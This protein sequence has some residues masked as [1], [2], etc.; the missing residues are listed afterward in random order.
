MALREVEIHVGFRGGVETKSDPKTVPPTKLLVL[1]NGVFT[2]ATSIKKRNGYES[3]SRSID[4]S[5]EVVSGAIRTAARDGELLAFT[6][7]R[8]YSRQTGADQW[9]DAGPVF[10]VVGSD[11]PLVRT[12]T[13][14]L[15]PDAASFAG[16]TV[17]AWEDSIGGVWWSV[18]DA[19]SGRVFRAATQADAAGQ[20]PRCVACGDNLHVYYSVPSTGRIM[21]VV[22]NPAAPGAAVAPIVLVDDLSAT[23]PAYDACETTRVSPAAAAIAWAE[24][25]TASIRIGYVTSAGVLGSPLSGLPSI[26]TH[27]AS[28]GATTPIGIAHGFVDGA[29]ADRLALTYVDG[30]ATGAIATFT[31]GSLASPITVVDLDVTYASTS[32]LRVAVGVSVAAPLTVWV[33]FEEAAVA[34]SNRRVAIISVNPATS[35]ATV[36]PVIRSVGLASRAFVVDADAFAVLVHDTTFFNT[37]VTLRLSDA[38]CIGRHAAA[39]AAGAP[40]RQHLSSAHVAGDIVTVALPVRER[41]VTEINDKFR[42]TGI[43][44]F[45]FDFDSED[46]HQAAQLGR[47]LYMAGACAQHYD[48]RVWTEQGFHFGPELVVTAPAGGGSMTASTTYLYRYWYE[49]TDAQGE[50]HRGPTSTGTIVTMAGGQTQVTHTLPTLRVT[51]KTQVRI[52]VARSLAADTGKTAQLFRVTSLDP[53]TVGVA[54]GYV[55]SSTAVDTVTFLDRMSD[56]TLE[57]QEELYTDG[58]ILSND[59][60]SL[61]SVIARG[62]SR[63][64]FTDPSDGN[65]VRFSQPIDDGYGV[66]IPPDLTI[67]C[68]P[69]GGDITA[70]AFQDGRGVI[71]KASA[72]FLFQGDGP[73]PN[74]DTSTSGFSTPQ[75]VTSDVG[76]T[77]PASIVLTP[78]GHM[79][80]SAK[81]IYLLDR[82]GSVSYIGA[83]VEAYN[84]QAVRRATVMPDRTQVV[85]LTD[86]GLTL[87]FDYLFGEW[88]TFT[89]HEGLDAVVVNN[90]YHYLRTDGRVFR[91]TPGVYSD[92][93]TRIRLRLETAWIRMQD[94][95][96]GFQ[97][98]WYLYLLG[99]WGSP[100]QLGVQYQTDYTPGWSNAY[101]YDATGL[102]SSTGWITGD[103]AAAIGIDPITGTGY[104]DGGYGEGAYGGT[105]P[106]LYQWRL[107]L[108][109]KGQAIQLRFEDFE[110]VGF[111]GASFELTEMLFTGGVIG[112]APRPSIAARSA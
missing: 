30:A 18:V 10:S 14:Q 58:G 111:L 67:R 2:R 36:G 108:S 23:L 98:F 13:Q 83:R 21:V 47:G 9:S 45:A 103:N 61:G 85:F 109:E 41:L 33:A 90:T 1:E 75:L 20:A 82:S 16:V 87:L 72:I 37:Y 31:G 40:L 76:C 69:F 19:V 42:E 77:D 97:V 52:C 102:S 74:G 105:T 88:S 55:L 26:L 60:A 62:Q 54:N 70:L 95:L 91:E 28:R 11:R 96:Q 110:A 106:D 81:G 6:P 64:F 80:K 66:E 29:N 68:D 5:A 15:Q 92:A 99:T 7:R 32:V 4:S 94:Q 63:L 101:W 57:Q 27:A 112:N 3:L 46:S 12:G 24:G 84:A 25:G 71:W 93:G 44:I 59:P 43:R 48:G 78:N 38:V 34:A 50:V 65:V 17:C 39:S 49:W 100:H 35:T 8:C 53:T 107:H 89:N 86:S 51:G 22:V 79:F 104:G 56:A 73:L